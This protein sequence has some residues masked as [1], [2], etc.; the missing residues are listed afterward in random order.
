MN[1]Q[2]VNV[3]SSV[4]TDFK[5]SRAEEAIKRKKIKKFLWTTVVLVLLVFLTWGG[6]WYSRRQTKN[7][8]G[9]FITDQGR[10]H[11]NAASGFIYNSN[12]PTSGPHF[13]Q[14]AEWGVYKEEL[15]DENLIHSLEHGG[16]WISYK[17]EISEEVRKKLEAFYEKYG[18]KIIVVPRSKNDSDI[19]LAAWNHLDKFSAAEYSDERVEKFIKALRNKGPEFVP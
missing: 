10:E 3:G 6:I 18:R 15:A 11:I 9:E 4:K 7:M 14:A 8:P 19:A 17:P 16:I 5:K 13:P 2:E 12:P 1:E